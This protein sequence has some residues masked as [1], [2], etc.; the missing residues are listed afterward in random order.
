VKFPIVSN[1]PYGL[2]RLR[3]VVVVVVVVPTHSWDRRLL[4]AMYETEP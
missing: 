4:F 2:V 3:L 1:V